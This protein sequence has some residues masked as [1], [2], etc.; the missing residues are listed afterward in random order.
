M[1]AVGYHATADGLAHTFGIVGCLVPYYREAARAAGRALRVV[2]VDL[3]REML[4]EA[5][6]RHGGGDDGAQFWLGDVVDFATAGEGEGGADVYEGPFD[7]VVF[8]SV[9]GN[10]YDQGAALARAAALT[11]EVR[12]RAIRLLLLSPSSS[13]SLHIHPLGR[14]RASRGEA[15]SGAPRP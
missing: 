11:R 5:R 6:R 2:G 14:A 9:F 8:N 10:L 7:A 3:S 15:L 12:A 1:R 4:D 13:P